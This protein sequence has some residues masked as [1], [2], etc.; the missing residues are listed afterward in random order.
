MSVHL[1][2]AMFSEIVEAAS[3]IAFVFT[4]SWVLRRKHGTRPSVEQERQG[5]RL[6]ALELLHL[7]SVLK[8]VHRRGKQRRRGLARS[9]SATI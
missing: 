2:N 7:Y 5:A 8:Q 6:L 3:F 4:A 9:V 1:A